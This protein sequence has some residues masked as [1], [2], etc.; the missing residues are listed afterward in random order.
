MGKYEAEP[1][2]R[3]EKVILEPITSSLIEEIR[4]KIV[5]YFNPDK[6]ILFGSAARNMQNSHDID[7]YIVKQRIRNVRETERKIDELFS[8]RFFAIDV[9]V[10]TPKQIEKSIKSGNSFLK[11]EIINKGKVLYEKKQRGKAELS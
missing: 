7:L 11:Q 9:I 3:K 2:K 1:M 4:D 5:K 8:G 10:R 6:I